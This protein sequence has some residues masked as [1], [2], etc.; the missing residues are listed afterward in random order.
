MFVPEKNKLNKFKLVRLPKPSEL[1]G[2]FGQFE[3][4][5][6]QYTGDMVAPMSSRKVDVLADMDEYDRMMQRQ[7]QEK[8]E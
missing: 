4:P 7:E 3:T 6:S 2:R 5:D 1:F 8:D